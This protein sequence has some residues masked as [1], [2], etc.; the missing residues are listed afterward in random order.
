MRALR[1]AWVSVLGEL[2]SINFMTM[3]ELFLAV[4]SGGNLLDVWPRVCLGIAANLSVPLAECG[5]RS[6][7]FALDSQW[8]AV[9]IAAPSP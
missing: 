8:A 7:G 3:A 9:D 4:S 2:L 5:L 6:F 1:A